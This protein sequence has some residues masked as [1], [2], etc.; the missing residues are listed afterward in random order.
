MVMVV[1]AAADS[2]PRTLV[3]FYLG[4]C[5]ARAF[6]CEPSSGASSRG[7]PRYGTRHQGWGK[8]SFGCFRALRAAAKQFEWWAI[9]PAIM[10]SVS[11]S[12]RS[13]RDDA[14]NFKTK[15]ECTAYCRTG[16]YTEKLCQRSTS[17]QTN[18]PKSLPKKTPTCSRQGNGRIQQ[19]WQRPRDNQTK[20]NRRITHPCGGS[21]GGGGSPAGAKLVL[22]V[23]RVPRQRARPGRSHIGLRD[24]GGRGQGHHAV[25]RHGQPPRGIS[26]PTYRRRR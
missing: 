5:R 8:G 16:D 26:P 20:P 4:S 13:A 11:T 10:C 7:V 22:G 3:W 15:E 21:G 25:L 18:K 14:S 2:V 19:T 9:G 23:P 24:A 6:E 17:Q 12:T 1:S